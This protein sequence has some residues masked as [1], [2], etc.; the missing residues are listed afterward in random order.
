MP[1]CDGAGQAVDHLAP[2]EA[3]A[4]EAHAA[5]GMETLAVVG[6]DAGGL[7]AAMLKRVQPKRRDRC[8]VRV[9]EHAEDATLLTQSVVVEA[10]CVGSFDQVAHL[11]S[12]SCLPNSSCFS[13]LRSRPEWCCLGSIS[14]SRSD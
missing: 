5:L 4:H 11:A 3:L 9:A 8:S 13:V 7:L 6:D 2:R 12:K 10:V 1:D 14:A